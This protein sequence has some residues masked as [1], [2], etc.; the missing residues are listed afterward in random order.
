[1]NDAKDSLIT[2]FACL[3]L[4]RRG[5]DRFDPAGKMHPLHDVKSVDLVVP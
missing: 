3:E 5:A 1:M 2:T 4:T